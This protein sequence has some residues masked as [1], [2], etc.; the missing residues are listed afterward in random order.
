MHVFCQMIQL[1][2]GWMSFCPAWLLKVFVISGEISVEELRSKKSELRLYCD[3]LMQQVASVKA[4]VTQPEVPDTKVREF[5]KKIDNFFLWSL[6]INAMKHFSLLMRLCK[7]RMKRETS[8]H[9]SWN[10]GC[11]AIWQL[12]AKPGNKTAAVPWPDP[13]EVTWYLGYAPSFSSVNCNLWFCIR[14]WKPKHFLYKQLKTW[15][16]RM[17]ISSI[18]AL[19]LFPDSSQLT[20]TSADL[21]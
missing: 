6:V 2:Q 15:G 14:F 10:C 4:A 18:I 12:I 8:E 9:L 21:Q 17:D 1:L 13:Y 7:C 20:K 3:L 19:I 5:W 16:P 11:H